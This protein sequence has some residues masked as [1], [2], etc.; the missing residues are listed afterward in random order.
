MEDIRYRE[1]MRAAEG[2]RRAYVEGMEALIS[3]REA[4]AR[5][6]RDAYARDIF[7]DQE[8]YREDYRRMLGWPLVGEPDH[9]TPAVR[10]EKLSEEKNISIYRITLEVLDGFSITGLLFRKGQ[11]RMPLVIAQH[12]GGGAPELMGN[13]YGDTHNYNHMAERMLAYDV[14][15]FAPQLLLWD[16]ETYGVEYDRVNLDARLKRVGSSVTAL[17]VYGLTR[18][19]DYFEAQEYVSNFGMI[20]LSYGGF[21][22]LFTAAADTRI[23]SAVACSFFN[24]RSDYAWSDWTWFGSAQTFSDAEIACLVY[25][26]R[27]CIEVGAKDELFAVE[28]AR[29]ELRRLRELSSS[30]TGDWIDFIEFDGTHEFCWEEESLRRLV[31]DI[32]S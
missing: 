5:A 6:E 16:K 12:G 24:T 18:I 30:V 7:R 20:G 29:A 4:K 23:K 32:Q 26:R 15:V 1:D 9:G 31:R 22:T 17:E 27:L 25:P 14:H 13:F 21:Y 28:G 10:L 8:K 2:C 11:E 19:L 3:G